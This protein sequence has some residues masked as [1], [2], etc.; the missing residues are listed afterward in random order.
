MF[1]L[2]WPQEHDEALRTW[3]A[4]GKT[5]SEIAY[6]LNRDFNTTY[7]RNAVIGRA[8]RMGL[9][10]QSGDKGGDASPKPKRKRSPSAADKT[11]I[12]ARS[13]LP[14]SYLRQADPRRNIACDELIDTPTGARDVPL[15]EVEGCRWPSGDGSAVAF[16]FCNAAKAFKGC[17]YCATHRRMSLRCAA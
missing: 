12:A 5:N 13:N 15:I 17:P 9:T 4:Q 2:K 16:T 10:S 8:N 3:V 11:R 1:K 6:L 7:S 14:V